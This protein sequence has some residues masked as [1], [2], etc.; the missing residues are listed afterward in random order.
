ML[1]KMIIMAILECRC[2]DISLASSPSGLY[3]PRVF[4]IPTL[5]LKLPRTI[6]GALSFDGFW[7]TGDTHSIWPRHWPLV[8]S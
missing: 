6:A 1:A 7:V 3:F 5:V 2:R 8:M 4:F